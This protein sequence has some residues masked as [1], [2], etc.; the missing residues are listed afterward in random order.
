MKTKELNLDKVEKEIAN[1][2]NLYKRKDNIFKVDI[3][4]ENKVN[5]IEKL[6]DYLNT[7][8]VNYTI[9][10]CFAGGS[11]WNRYTTILLLTIDE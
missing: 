10:I 7:N 9:S 3:E 4:I 11:Y 8:F 1:N 2:F 6:K 5:K